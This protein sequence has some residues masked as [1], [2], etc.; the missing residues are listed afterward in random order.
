[1]KSINDAMQFKG[2]QKLLNHCSCRVLCCL[3]KQRDRPSSHEK[4]YRV[5]LKPSLWVPS[6]SPQSPIIIDSVSLQ[7]N[8]V[9]LKTNRKCAYL[10]VCLQICN[11][12]IS[13][14]PPEPLVVYLV[15]I[16]LEPLLNNFLRVFYV[17]NIVFRPENW[18]RELA[19]LI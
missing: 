17:I 15:Y 14:K 12:C 18:V 7:L 16:L 10:F 9:I 19:F 1:M 13:Y 11:L 8:I 2:E 6:T 3:L 5:Q 4:E